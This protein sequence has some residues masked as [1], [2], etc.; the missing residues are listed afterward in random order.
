MGGSELEPLYHLI[1]ILKIC[2]KKY[3]SIIWDQ[4]NISQIEGDLNSIDSSLDSVSRVL[5]REK[6]HA[7]G[8]SE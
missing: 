8:T 3:F 6:K 7:T 4:C 5:N 1:N 2:D